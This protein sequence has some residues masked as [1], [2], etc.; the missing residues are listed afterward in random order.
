MRFARLVPFLALCFAAPLAAAGA[1]PYFASYHP[2]E[3]TTTGGLGLP[4]RLYRPAGAAKGSLPLLLLLH[5]ITE[6]GSDNLRP[7]K[8]FRPFLNDTFYSRHAC[9][10]AMPQC[11]EFKF[12]WQKTPMD[13]LEALVPGLVA[14]CPEIDP[15]R[16]YVVG[17]SL[18]GYAVYALL[19]RDAGMFSAAVSMSGD[20]RPARL[21]GALLKDFPL[22]IFHGS[23]DRR[24][25]VEGDRELYEQLKYLDKNAKYTEIPGAGHVIW[26]E[27]LLKG[28]MWDWLFAQSKP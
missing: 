5:S 2:R 11:P 28:D 6:R 8:F 16:V 15:K 23:K 7:Y 3:V 1:D 22:W 9:A 21:D 14:E 20:P 13:C 4:Y 12:W 26:P 24:V 10:I 17:T 18:G 25:P 27:I 19:S